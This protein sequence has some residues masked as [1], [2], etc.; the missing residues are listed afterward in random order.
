MY[1]GTCVCVSFCVRR[2]TKTLLSS[3]SFRGIGRRRSG[4]SV[5]SIT[6]SFDV[7][8]SVTCL[9][10]SQGSSVVAPH[11]GDTDHK[12]Y[13]LPSEQC[14]RLLTLCIGRRVGNWTNG[15]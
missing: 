5:S 8:A 15:V 13:T 2:T 1:V 14:L 4:R 3:I 12:D 7:T 9:A 11:L 10:Q 6:H